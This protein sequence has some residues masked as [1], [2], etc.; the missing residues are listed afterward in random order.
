VHLDFFDAV[1]G[2]VGDG[3]DVRGGDS[4]GNSSTMR[5]REHDDDEAAGA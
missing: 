1:A 2:V 5:L 4:V 3:E